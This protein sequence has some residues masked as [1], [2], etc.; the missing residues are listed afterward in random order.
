M[1]FQKKLHT[2]KRNSK[3]FQLLQRTIPHSLLNL[4]IKLKS[5]QHRGI[6]CLLKR[7]SLNNI[8]SL[9]PD[10]GLTRLMCLRLAHHFKTSY[11]F[12]YNM[13][14]Q[15]DEALLFEQEESLVRDLY[16]PL[17]LTHIERSQRAVFTR[18]SDCLL[19]YTNVLAKKLIGVQSGVTRIPHSILIATIL[20]LRASG[21]SEDI[22]EANVSELTV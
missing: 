7:N 9:K 1:L 10:E 20:I 17:Q 4:L 5:Q 11:E 6:S 16:L 2:L 14:K 12:W 3:Q 19:G 15:Y 18:D 22:Q 8:I 13:Q 21:A